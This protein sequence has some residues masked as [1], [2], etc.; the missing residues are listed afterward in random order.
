ME[1][2][3]PASVTARSGTAD[4][5]EE[6]IELSSVTETDIIIEELKKHR[7]LLEQEK[8]NLMGE[9]N[10]L[11]E[12][13]SKAEEE[14]NTLTQQ[15]KILTEKNKQE[16]EKLKEKITELKRELKSKDDVTKSLEARIKTLEEEERRVKSDQNTLY[17]SQV[18]YQF[19]QA[20]CTYVL[21]KVFEKDQHATIKSLLEYLHGK[22]QLPVPDR[23][24]RLLL[25]GR[26]QWDKV[27][28]H[29]NLPTISEGVGDFTQWG[30]HKSSTPDIIKAL[31]ILKRERRTIAHPRPISL[32]LAEE[33]L[34]AV[35]GNMPPWQ[36]DLIEGFV[37]S[38]QKSIEKSGP[39]IY[40]KHFQLDYM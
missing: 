11:K 7:N 33:K 5:L 2:Y 8:S 25:E 9:L 28:V 37:A 27:C 31:C 20:I 13:V 6:P 29:L 4:S 38:V 1:T 14:R 22:N 21:P 34:S 39:N 17:I 19:E 32:T 36:F 15:M 24:G 23:N 30:L 12:K 3:N 18:A 10:K 26:K 40:S 16:I 35:K